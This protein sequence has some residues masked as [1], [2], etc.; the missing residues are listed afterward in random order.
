MILGYPGRV[1]LSVARL[2]QE[3]EALG[4]ILGQAPSTNHDNW[5]ILTDGFNL[6]RTTIHEFIRSIFLLHLL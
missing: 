2:D 3:P 5:H 1:A 4:S 6:F